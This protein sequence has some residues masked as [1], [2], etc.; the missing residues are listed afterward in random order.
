MPE[1]QTFGAWLKQRRK[2]IDLTQESLA[3][4]A[5]CSVEMVRKIEASTA[6]PSRQ[7]A[8]LL[9]VCVQAPSEERADLVQWARTG[10]PKTQ[11]TT[12]G[13]STPDS[14]GAGAVELD[15]PNPYKGLR[16]FHEADAGDF[17]GREELTNQ[18]VARLSE[19]AELSRFLAVVG[20]SG[21]GKSSVVRAG[22]VP[23]LRN[24]ALPRSDHWPVAEM[25]PGT[26][27]L[28]E[29]EAALLRLA[30]NPPASLLPQLKEDERGLLR[31]VKRSIP[32]HETSGL[33]LVIDQFE[34][35]FTLVDDEAARRHFL[36]SLHAAVTDARSPVRV[37]TTLR[38]DFYDRPLLYANP[39]ELLRSRT[40]V[41]LPMSPA[42]LERAI[43]CPAERVGVALESELP[44]AIIRDVGEQVG[45]LP[46]MQYALT[47]LF[48]KREGRLMTVR[49]YQSSGG[50]LGTLARRAEAI[51]TA[52]DSPQQEI[53][54]QLFLR[55]VTLGEGI[56]DT[57]RR[58]RVGELISLTPD[59]ADL[60]QV[61]DVFGRYRLLTFDRHPQTG[62]PT[63]EVAHEALLRVWP[64]LRGWLDVSREDLRLQQRL[65][66]SAHEWLDADKDHSFLAPGARLAQFEALAAGGE[67]ALNAEER[68]YLEASVAERDRH[69]Q[70]ERERRE[71]ELQLQKRDAGR[72]RLLV[73]AL[74]IFLVAAIGLLLFALTNQSE[75]NTQR[76]RAESAAATAVAE[77]SNADAQRSQAESNSARS[78]ALRLAAEANSLLQAGGRPELSA[79]LAIRS[80]HTT[81]TPQGDAALGLSSY[82][83]YPRQR[84]IGHAGSIFGVAFSPDGRYVATSSWDKT[85]RLWDAQTGKEIRT[86]S[87]HEDH[88]QRI[89]FSPDGKHLLT[90]S[91][92]QT[93]RLWDVQTGKEERTF[94]GHNGIVTGVAFSSDGEYV[95]TGS[96]DK[97][98]KLWD[99][100]TGQEVRTFTG[101]GEQVDSVALSTDGKYALTGSDDRTARLWDV[102]TGK[103]VRRFEGHTMPVFAVAIS[104]DGARVLTGSDDEKARLW[105]AQTGAIVHTF[106]ERAGSISSLAFSP[107]GHSLITG[108]GTGI[109]KLWD[110][111]TGA[112]LLTLAGHAG[113]VLAVAFSPDGKTVLTGGYDWTALA[114]DTQPHHELP[115]FAGHDAA[116]WSV[117]FSPDGKY[118]ISSSDDNT[119]RI[120]DATSGK[121]L[122]ILT[123]HDAPVARAL[124]APDGKTLLTTSF[125]KT[126]KL[127]DAAT[128]TPLRV[129]EGHEDA[130]VGAAFSPDGRYV[131]T[132]S[133]DK[134]ARV[135]DAATG[136]QVRVLT[137]HSREVFSLAF[138]PD[139]KYLL[140][141]SFDKTARLWD[142]DTGTEIRQFTG[143]TEH[144]NHVEISPDGRYVLT[145]SD[146]KTARLWDIS[147]GKLV[148]TFT[149]HTDVVVQAAFSPD[150]K[151]I[152]TGSFDKTARLWDTQTGQELRRFTSQGD[153]PLVAFSPDGR[154]VL[155]GS[156]DGAIRLWDTDYSHTVRYLCDRLTRDFSADERARYAITGDE[157]TCSH[158]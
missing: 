71:R 101:H 138:S 119:A 63:I 93:A 77:K 98:A 43:V 75:A 53:A 67:V 56:E 83:E 155:T 116:L 147:T 61:L 82:L 54:R 133:M 34:E 100:Q 139:G 102:Q 59:E 21:S 15:V 91:F 35:V 47:E 23:A 72:L 2:D 25:T 38:A 137:G 135:W 113:P 58:V 19:D 146:D 104:P 141:G 145:T 11:A 128:G 84:F 103:E 156:N 81:Y 110:A 154:L 62:A 90:G 57:R 18:L 52:L 55:L 152:V 118:I 143:H 68:A 105:D 112:N 142:L 117:A 7:L 106:E 130:V 115:R 3:E 30:V 86:F 44:D 158:P 149:G 127:W 108:H 45:A 33:V 131:A 153:L 46:L 111:Q 76:A 89:A 13:L 41:V 66:Q 144:V 40:E 4:Q 32:N 109:A 87:G 17:F 6:R 29:L 120:W 121:D 49:A 107:D 125:D 26:H 60:H 92:D 88:L 97:T 50:V 51:Y 157:S 132:G 129:L 1:T 69:E 136:K 31:A 151:R 80:L 96:E 95:L 5:G 150:G 22:L 48:D 85:A 114:W 14:E 16:A 27:P 134:S 126:A 9:V 10:T 65:L 123:G 36:D 74:T 140:T 8:E 28:E 99:A 70:S 37:I 94:R 78:E 122:R 39:G 20:P 148:R 79:L 73:S 12:A 64:R 124:F 42:E 24:G